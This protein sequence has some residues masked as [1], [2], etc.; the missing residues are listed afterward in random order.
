MA[1]L[2]EKC[3]RF[4]DEPVDKCYLYWVYKSCPGRDMNALCISLNPKISSKIEKESIKR[5]GQLCFLKDY[6]FSFLVYVNSGL[7]FY[8]VN[9][10]FTVLQSCLSLIYSD[11][12]NAYDTSIA[13]LKTILKLQIII[14]NFFVLTDLLFMWEHKNSMNNKMLWVKLLMVYN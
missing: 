12:V 10:D 2:Y 8:F 5:F 13:R 6:F 7:I 14:K 3:H 11:R 1:K 4:Y 9:S